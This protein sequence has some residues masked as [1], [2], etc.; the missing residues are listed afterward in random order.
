MTLRD[1]SVGEI[2]AYGDGH[3]T[4]MGQFDRDPESYYSIQ[5]TAVIKRQF[6]LVLLNPD[7]TPAG[8]QYYEVL[9]LAGAVVLT[10]TTVS[11]VT[12][13]FL[14]TFTVTNSQTFDDSY[15]IRA[16]A[17][18]RE[19]SIWFNITS[20]Q[21]VVLILHEVEPPGP[22][23]GGARSGV[24]EVADSSGFS[25]PLPVTSVMLLSALGLAAIIERRRRL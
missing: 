3:I 13:S 16:A 1:S 24:K 2:V 4:I 23:A 11:D 7:M 25:W 6:Q 19:G 15:E 22:L 5:N 17:S 18:G 12:S 9:N 20:T 14:F 21:P 8:F 10:G